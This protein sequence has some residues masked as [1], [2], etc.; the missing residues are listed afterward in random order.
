MYR[1][2][3]IRSS[4]SCSPSAVRHTTCNSG[5][6]RRRH[7]RKVTPMHDELLWRDPNRQSVMLAYR[8]PSGRTR[9]L[10]PVDAGASR[11]VPIHWPRRPVNEHCFLGCQ[12]VDLSPV[13][14][15]EMGRPDRESSLLTIRPTRLTLVEDGQAYMIYTDFIL[16]CPCISG[17]PKQLVH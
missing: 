4:Y 5:E 6:E 14:R 11:L 2:V 9:T 15:L 7:G 10:I 8:S 1:W 3:T 12:R 16:C 13:P 17:R